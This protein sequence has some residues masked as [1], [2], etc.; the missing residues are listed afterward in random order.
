M[1]KVLFGTTAIVAA[2]FAG[3]ALANGSVQHNDGVTLKVGGYF[4]AGVGIGNFSE[5]RGEYDAFD[6][7][8]R[9]Y[10]STLNGEDLEKDFHI[11]NDGEIHFKAKGT[12]DNGIGIE[13]RVELEAFGEGDV[14]D[15]HWMKVK[16]AFG[17]ILI[18][19]NDTALDNV[20]GGIGRMKGGIAGGSWDHGYTFVPGA[21]SYH[22][23]DDG[24]NYAIHYYTPNI[25]GFEFGVSYAPDLGTDGVDCGASTGISTNCSVS[26]SNDLITVGASWAG[27]LGD[28]DLAIGGGYSTG[29]GDDVAGNTAEVSTWGGGV[30]LGFGAVTIGGAYL[31]REIEDNNGN[32]SLNTFLA[33]DEADITQYGVGIEYENGPWVFGLS[34]LIQDVDDTTAAAATA[35]DFDSFLINGAIGYELGDGVNLGLGIDYG[36]VDFDNAAFNDE[37]GFGGKLLLGVKF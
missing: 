27:T 31:N 21:T 6:E 23:G 9:E 16:T 13:V 29:E 20:A 4:V 24:D 3:Q 34:G 18:G 14:I 1:K 7:D 10:A 22:L 12:L 32:G 33:G 2:A 17:T 30:E 25:S 8:G 35:A 15:E 36:E 5:R 19:S 37:E 26:N 28:I 11:I